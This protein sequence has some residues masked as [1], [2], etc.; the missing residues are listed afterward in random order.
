MHDI[1]LAKINKLLAAK[2]I[3]VDLKSLKRHSAQGLM[4]QV[5]VIQSNRGRLVVHINQMS[6]EQRRQKV[7]KKI[8]ALGSFLEKYKNIPSAKVFAAGSLGDKY[9]IVQQM[10]SGKPAGAR[11]LKSDRIV[12]I[13]YIDRSKLE[14]QVE[15]ATS[16]INSIRMTGAGWLI[17]DKGLL[18]GQYKNWNE[19]LI[20]EIAL[21]QKAI[22]KKESNNVITKKIQKYFDEVKHDLDYKKSFLVHNDLT[23][24]GNILYQGTK[25]TG[26][27]DW[28]WALAGDPAWEFAFNNQYSLKQYLR[29]FSSKE[30]VAFLKRVKLYEPIYLAWGLFIHTNDHDQK[31]YRLLKNHLVKSLRS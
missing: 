27:V 9:F 1:I 14:R 16:K 23:N 31:L 21:W 6:T 30:K 24:P 4:S 15:Q 13:W 2:R 7:W 3:I 18:R 12:D 25:L 20:K 29:S 11:V 17:S 22:T 10:I 5:F 28:E 26:L 8:E 19:F